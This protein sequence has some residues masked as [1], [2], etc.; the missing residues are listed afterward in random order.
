[1]A[2]T[3][4][5]ATGRAPVLLRTDVVPAGPFALP[6][7]GLDGLARRRAG[8][9]VRLVHFDGEPVL[10]H[11]AQ[12]ARDRVAFTARAPSR[13]AAA[14]GIERMRFA[15]AV[16]DDLS[17]FRRRFAD[18]PLIGPS[19][20]RR[21]GLRVRRRPE[22][23][24]ALVFAICAQLIE[25][26]RA[27]AIQRR[28]V[29]RLGRRCAHSGLR[30]LPSPAALAGVAPALL[31]SLDLAAGRAV[32]M[33]R[34][35][36]EVAGGRLDL[37]AATPERGWRRLLAIPG[38]GRW[39]VETLALHGQGRY[40]QLPAGDLIYLRLVGRH[41]SGGDPHARA[42]EAQVRALFAPYGEWAALAA[43]HLLA[44]RHRERGSLTRPARAG[45]RW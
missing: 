15:L 42:S 43:A 8:G 13:A 38:V 31:Q 27:A 25:A 7:L 28:I 32:A 39:T 3:E 9:L 10:V 34:V 30:D 17:E 41:L 29:A 14:Y 18:D 20:R 4:A 21:P 6:G 24:E 40:D 26:E 23:F 37:F 1:M 5:T 35:A 16:D 12:P 33:L 22:P 45:T 11:A 19:V 2:A 36:R 44:D